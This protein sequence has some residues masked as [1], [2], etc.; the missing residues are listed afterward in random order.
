MAGRDSV[1]QKLGFARK[2]Q[3]LLQINAPY[4]PWTENQCSDTLV[5]VKDQKL[6]L[7]GG[8]IRRM[9]ESRK[10]SQEKL[11]ELAG[12]DRAYYGGIERGERNVAA[13]N[14]VKIADAL[15]VEVGQLF[16]PISDLRQFMKEKRP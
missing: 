5:C 6:V 11:A 7:L 8:R 3:C 14:I 12:I 2:K 16:P 9:R 10:I 15:G 4:R 13:V 1:D